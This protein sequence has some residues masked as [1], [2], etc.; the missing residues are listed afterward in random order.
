PAPGGVFHAL[1]RMAR[2]GLG[3][4]VA[5]GGQF[6]SWIHDRDFVRAVTFLLNGDDLAGPVNLAAPHPVPQRHLL[7]TLPTQVGMPI[8]P[9][10]PGWRAELGAF[11]IRS[12]TE[13][14]LKSRRV[15]PTRLLDAGFAF[16]YPHWPEAARELARRDA[17]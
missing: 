2:L 7:R 3:G 9:P 8:G 4:A 16:D 12:D 6:V 17:Q 1:R 13:L 5:G 14:L 11:V 10:A 15:V